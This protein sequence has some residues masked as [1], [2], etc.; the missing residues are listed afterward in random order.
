M[1]PKSMAQAIMLKRA[2][3]EAEVEDDFL[4]EGEEELGLEEPEEEV[5][6]LDKRKALLAKIM[7]DLK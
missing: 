7:M 6:D 3:P 1:N 4:V 5:S 2:A